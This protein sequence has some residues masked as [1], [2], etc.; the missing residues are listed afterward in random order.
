MQF[1]FGYVVLHSLY[2]FCILR[3]TF[4]CPSPLILKHDIHIK[5]KSYKLELLG[6]LVI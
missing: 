3:D 2:T 4:W 6:K 5:L 1:F